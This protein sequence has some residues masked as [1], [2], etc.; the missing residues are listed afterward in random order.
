MRK[1]ITVVVMVLAMLA[2]AGAVASAATRP[3]GAEVK[4]ICETR[5]RGD[6][7]Y[8][9]YCMRYGTVLD[10][11]RMWLSIPL[12]VKGRESREAYDRRSLCKFAGEFGGVRAVAREAVFDMAYDRFLNHESVIRGTQRVAVWDCARL[13]RR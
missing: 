2:G 6:A 5:G 8:R 9:R 7:D 4:R 10:G 13:N 12:G 1:I 3:T 11:A